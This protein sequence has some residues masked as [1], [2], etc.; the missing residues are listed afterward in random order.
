[1]ISINSNKAQRTP[2]FMWIS[3]KL[4]ASHKSG[5]ISVTTVRTAIPS[6]AIEFLIFQGFQPIYKHVLVALKMTEL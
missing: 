3:L 2:I 4:N 5:Y 1:M 6:P